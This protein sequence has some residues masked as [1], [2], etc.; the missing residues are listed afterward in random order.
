VKRTNLNYKR[1]E[2]GRNLDKGNSFSNRKRRKPR[3]KQ[4]KKRNVKLL[5]EKL[6]FKERNKNRPTVKIKKRPSK[7]E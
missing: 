4:M 1:I 2:K 6:R 3:N 7:L 5:N